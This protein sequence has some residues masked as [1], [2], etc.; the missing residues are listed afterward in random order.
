M[1]KVLPL[2]EFIQRVHNGRIFTVT[3]T[4]RNSNEVRTMNCRMGVEKHKVGVQLPYDPITKGLIMVYSIDAKGYRQ[5][6]IEGLVS[7]VLD[8]TLYN[9]D[10]DTL[11]FKEVW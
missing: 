1:P 3:F 9:Y 10:K 11:E 6:P 7:L 2:E 8:G 4:K 5:I